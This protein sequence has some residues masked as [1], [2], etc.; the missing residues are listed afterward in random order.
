MPDCSEQSHVRSPRTLEKV[1]NRPPSDDSLTSAA[2]RIP[3]LNEM[4]LDRLIDGK[5]EQ[6]ILAQARKLTIENVR[7]EDYQAYDLFELREL[8][9]REVALSLGISAVTVRVRAF[10]VRRAVEREVRRI[11]KMLEQPNR[12]GR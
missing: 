6:A 2:N 12:C 4:E 9:A 8:G 11:A 7:M 1:E 3:D 5:L 10:R